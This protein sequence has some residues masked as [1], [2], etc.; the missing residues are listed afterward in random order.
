M[1]LYHMHWWPL[2]GIY[3]QSLVEVPV[4]LNFVRSCFRRQGFPEKRQTTSK[5]ALPL[6]KQQKFVG[7]CFF[8]RAAW[9]NQ[10]LSGPWKR[11]LL[12]SVEKRRP[13]LAQWHLLLPRFKLWLAPMSDRDGI[14]P[15]KYNAG[16]WRRYRN[17]SNRESLID[18][19]TKFSIVTS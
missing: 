2:H 5:N 12:V 10:K 6:E 7:K 13:Q 15:Y 16:K 17:I 19:N 8:L 4:S 11:F 18:P 1:A 9:G 3:K 14:S